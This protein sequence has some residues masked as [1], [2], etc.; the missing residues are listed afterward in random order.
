MEKAADISLKKKDEF[1]SCEDEV[2]KKR[3]FIPKKVRQFMRRK[4]KLLKCL[5]K[6]KCWIK[7]YDN[8]KELVEVETKLDEI[9]KQRRLKKEGDAIKKLKTNPKYFY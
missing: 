7:N 5:M 1:D 9:Y 8:M 3:S 4:E 6:S 2:K